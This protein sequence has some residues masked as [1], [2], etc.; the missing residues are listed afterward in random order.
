M[1]KTYQDTIT[2]CESK[3]KNEPMLV[4]SSQL[5]RDQLAAKIRFHDAVKDAGDIIR[6]AMM[7]VNFS[8][9]DKFCDATKLR[10]SWEKSK[11]PEVLLKFFSSLFKINKSH[12]LHVD[13]DTEKDDSETDNVCND[14]KS[15]GNRH[16]VQLFSLL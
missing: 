10:L 6:Q 8:L 9:Q 14:N 11:M 13:V 15:A 5:S 2:L 4:F 12:L 1:V 3:R 16:T 7:N